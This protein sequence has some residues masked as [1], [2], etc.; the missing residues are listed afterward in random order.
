MSLAQPVI[1]QTLSLDTM[2]DQ[3]TVSLVVPI[4]VLRAPEAPATEWRVESKTELFEDH[5]TFGGALCKVTITICPS[6]G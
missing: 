2:T 4:R 1:A 3:R 6:A 5:T